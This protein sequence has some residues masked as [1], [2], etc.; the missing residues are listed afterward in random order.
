M[1][2]QLDINDDYCQNKPY[3]DLMI[4]MMF[5]CVEDYMFESQ[6]RILYEYLYLSDLTF[7]FIKKKT[8]GYC[9]TITVNKI[10]RAN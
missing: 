4:K 5:F 8:D 10:L 2:F 1:Y 9:M 7:I 3:F 6:M